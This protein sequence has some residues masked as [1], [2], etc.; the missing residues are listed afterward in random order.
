M[1]EKTIYFPKE[2][3]EAMLNDEAMEKVAGGF[4]EWTGPASGNVIRCPF[5]KE[6][7]EP[8]LFMSYYPGDDV[9]QYD[10]QSCGRTFYVDGNGDHYTLTNDTLYFQGNYGKVR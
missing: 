2:K 6:A 4:G 8:N 7:A 5:C 1:K 9:A 10:C 3:R